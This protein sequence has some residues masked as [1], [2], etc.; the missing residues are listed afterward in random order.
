MVKLPDA[1][2][3]RVYLFIEDFM[4]LFMRDTEAE[5]QA[6]EEAGSPQGT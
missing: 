5:T 6:E 4:Y 2:F 3:L 1:F